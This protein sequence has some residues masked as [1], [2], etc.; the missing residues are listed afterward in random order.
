MSSQYEVIINRK[1]LKQIQELPLQFR[2]R[3][4]VAIDNL[5]I[6][7]KHPNC[8]KLQGFDHTWRV[9]VGDYRII[10][11]IYDNKVQII[12]IKVKHR[13]DVYRD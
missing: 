8:K 12:V 10:Y 11:E 13:R 7:P 2:K 6:N 3:V 5:A 1:A 4:T 9:R